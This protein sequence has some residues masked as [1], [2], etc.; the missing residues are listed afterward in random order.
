MSKVI[1]LLALLAVLSLTA[2]A[3]GGAASAP[4]APAVPAATTPSE[5]QQIITFMKALL[6]Q[7][8]DSR[9]LDKEFDAYLDARDKLTKAQRDTKE[10]DMQKR[11]KAIISNAN[12]ISRP[13]IPELKAFYDP[14]LAF[15]VNFDDMLTALYKGDVT[16]AGK[17]IDKFEGLD[18]AWRAAVN[19]MLVK[20]S[21]TVTDVG[22]PKD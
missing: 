22:W 11:A 4:A 10:A 3:P 8:M 21:L 2:C 19:K 1:A 15:Q 7:E 20:Y 6:P 17:L 14:W 12:A 16:T 18:A 9:V 5:K 13:N